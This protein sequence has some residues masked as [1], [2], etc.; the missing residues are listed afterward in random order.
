MRRVVLAGIAVALA[1]AAVIATT[2]ALAYPPTAPASHA[3]PPPNYP[4][5]PFPALWQSNFTGT[6]L[7]AVFDGGTLL[8]LTYGNSTSS[9]PPFGPSYPWDLLAINATTGA[10]VWTHP[11]L[12]SDEA[13]AIPQ[14]VLD[15]GG[16]YF[17]QAG[18]NLS[19]DSTPVATG[20][21]LFAVGF[22]PDTGAQ[23]SVT[24]TP[25]SDSSVFELVG[26]TAY[27]GW[28]S[29]S[30]A[31]SEVTVESVELLDTPRSLTLWSTSFASGGGDTNLPALSV[32]GSF[33]VVPF[34]EL[35]VLNAQTGA[36][37]FGASFSL[38]GAGLG[39][40][41][42]NDALIGGE[43]Y[44]VSEWTQA[45]GANATVD[46]DGLNLTSQALELNTTIQSS[47]PVSAQ[48]PVRNYSDELVVELDGSLTVAPGSS[49][50]FQVYSAQGSLLWSSSGRTVAGGPGAAAVPWGMPVA[51]LGGNT[52]LLSSSPAA[53][54]ANSTATQYFVTAGASDG[55][56]LWAH[57]FPF[58]TSPN[59]SQLY[60][61]N[62]EG[63]RAVVILTTRGNEVPYRWGFSIGLTVL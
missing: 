62:G 48:V 35:G 50:E 52:W 37:L 30:G 40:D 28:S 8:A 55:E 54:D 38:L 7:T 4:S 6:P 59:N 19:V 3:G 61:P 15:G 14:L 20:P 18:D 24:Q 63:P 27:I 41:L 39:F 26:D 22:N 60:P 31:T 23:L 17:V 13:N 29:D 1:A 46:L 32:D 16:V 9:P 21:G 56:M 5:E 25:A 12:V 34:G 2:L 45:G 42:V 49:A 36:V 43:L 10:V 33:L 47:A 57:A 11:I 58:S 53:S 51:V 44:F